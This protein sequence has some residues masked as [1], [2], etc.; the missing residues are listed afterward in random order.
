MLRIEDYPRV[1]HDT[2]DPVIDLLGIGLVF[3]ARYVAAD[4]ADA[5][6]AALEKE[7]YQITTYEQT[8]AGDV[9]C[10]TVQAPTNVAA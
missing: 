8:R 2:Y 3:V 10:L 5:V 1:D 7:G 4:Y 9:Y 6:L